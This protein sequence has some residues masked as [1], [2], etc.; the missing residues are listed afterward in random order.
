MSVSSITEQWA[1]CFP[2][3][4]YE[5]LPGDV[6]ELAKTALLDFLGVALAG[7]SMPMATICADYFSALG[8]RPEASL[9][10]NPQRVPAIHA[11]TVNGVLGHALDM[12]DGHRAASGHPGI[13][14][15]PA[16]LAAAETV[17]ASGRELLRAVVFGYEVFVRLGAAVN[18][19]HLHRGFHT[20]ATIGP[21]A[22]AIAAGVLKGL[23]GERLVRALGL[24]GVQGAGLMEVFHDGAM[25]K[26]FQ[27]ARASAAGLLAAELAE[28]GAGGPRTILEGEHGFL[29]AMAGH[30]DGGGRAGAESLVAGLGQDW[31][32]RGVYFKAHAACRHT[33]PAIDAAA[34]LRREH[35]ITPEQ[36]RGAV[37]QTYEVADRLCGRAELP[38]GPSEAK[39]SLPFAVALGLTLGHARAS[40]FTPETVADE[41]LRALA[42]RVRVEVDPALDRLYPERR[43]AILEV[44]TVDGR[45]LRIEAPLA[46]GEPELPLPPEELEAKFLDNARAAIPDDRAVAL[47]ETVRALDTQETCTRL[48]DL[49][50]GRAAA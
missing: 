1:D 2:S 47:L 38:P 37:V 19:A 45:C 4:P 28:R 5:A 34:T 13:V 46:R 14:T 48:L 10:A 42:T 21:F 36:V 23:Q 18:P 49:L 29:R 12:D 8:G 17:G 41:Q 30:E 39:F 43:P 26:P 15:L 32:I 6:T 50:A 22:A 24:A 16:A 9:I 3:L 25:A 27:T 35:G 7:S 11:A 31:A 20:S 44:T 33:H 40:C